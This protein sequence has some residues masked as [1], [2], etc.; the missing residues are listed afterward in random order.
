[1]REE[2]R[3]KINKVDCGGGEVFHSSGSQSLFIQQLFTEV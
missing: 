2:K 3:G 1:M